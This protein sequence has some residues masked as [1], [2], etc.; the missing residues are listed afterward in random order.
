MLIQ[1]EIPAEIS[2]HIGLGALFQNLSPISW[3][4]LVTLLLLSI[5]SWGVILSKALLFRK[6]SAESKMFWKVFR[7]SQ[8]LTEVAKACEAE[9]MRF[10][11]LAPVFMAGM[12]MMRPRPGGHSRGSVA[13]K[14]APRI[15]S[16]SRSMQ[17][18]ATAEMTALEQ[19]LPM[20]ATTA[21]VAP[22]VGLFG[23]VWGVLTSFLGLSNETNATLQ[24][25][26]PG[27]AEALIATAFG[28]GAAIPAVV[29]YNHFVH[30]MRTLGAEIDELQADMLN[31]AEENDDE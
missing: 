8:S 25:V 29:S 14:T 28:L 23:T 24:A 13:V 17:R 11:P 7:R 15:A 21:S 27:I 19:R 18:T 31:M 10:T 20:L 16:V 6:I 2:T 1:G 26:G 3:V 4:V 5:W 30:R 12:E 9:E 22:F